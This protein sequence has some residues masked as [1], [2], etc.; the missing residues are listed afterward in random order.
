MSDRTSRRDVLARA[1]TLSVSSVAVVGTSVAVAAAASR[2]PPDGVTVEYDEDVITEYQPQLILD[3][4]EPDPLA[5]HA[6]HAT[7]RDSSMAAVYGFV[8]Y[9]YQRGVTSEDSHL[10]DHE[11]LIVFYDESNGEVVRVDYAA[12]HWFRGWAEGSAF[13]YADDAK[14]QPILRVDPTYHHYYQYQG[15]YPG[16][17][18]EVRDLTASIGGWLS[19]GMEEDLAT[20]QPYDPWAMLGRESWWKHT[21]GNWFNAFFKALWFNLGFAGARDTSDLSGVSTW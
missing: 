15:S 12:Y 16:E 14:H 6:L 5:F 7:K 1:G 20:S 11:P 17:T 10:G 3:G 13:R 21:P 18:L 8:Q 4:V 2:A 19:N 9:P